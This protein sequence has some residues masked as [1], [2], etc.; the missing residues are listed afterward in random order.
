FFSSR[1]RHT[2]WPRD[3]SSDVCSSDL[4]WLKRHQQS[5]DKNLVGERTQSR[6]LSPHAFRRR[7]GHDGRQRTSTMAQP[8]TTVSFVNG[9]RLERRGLPTGSLFVFSCVTTTHAI[10]SLSAILL[11]KRVEQ[12]CQRADA[13]RSR[14][15]TIVGCYFNSARRLFKF[16]AIPLRRQIGRA[17]V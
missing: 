6:T 2:R 14:H 7:D 15:S 13:A 10:S 12:A 17:H 3:W 1:R 5:G 8:L 16:P 11:L 9:S 4:K